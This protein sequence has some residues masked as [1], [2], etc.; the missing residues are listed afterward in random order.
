VTPAGFP[1]GQLLYQLPRCA[2][3]RGAPHR[4][5]DDG[6]LLDELQGIEQPVGGAVVAGGEFVQALPAGPLRQPLRGQGGAAGSGTGLEWLAGVSGPGDVGV[7]GGPLQTGAPG[8]ATSPTAAAERRRRTGWPA[9]GPVAI[10]SWMEVVAEPT[11]SGICSAT[12]SV[13]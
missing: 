11:S 4:L 10:R 3:V 9:R 1:R 8:W 7:E 12:G 6:E 13:G 2:H 5:L